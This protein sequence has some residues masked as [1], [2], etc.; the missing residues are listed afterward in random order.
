MPLD[1]LLFE[2]IPEGMRQTER[3]TV[4]LSETMTDRHAESVECVSVGQ[5]VDGHARYEL[6][7][8]F[9]DIAD[10]VGRLDEYFEDADCLF[11]HLF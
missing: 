11:D 10:T 8:V 5:T 9:A 6:V 7:S 4:L 2:Q 3:H 1:G